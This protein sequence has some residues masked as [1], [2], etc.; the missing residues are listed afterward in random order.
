MVEGRLSTMYASK[1]VLAA[2]SDCPWVVLL[3]GLGGNANTWYK[4]QSVY[5]TQFNL[6]FI[7]LHSVKSSINKDEP[8]TIEAVCK[9]ISDTMDHQGVK[10]AHFVCLSIGT[11]IALAFAATY[12]ERVKSMVLVGGIIKFNIRTRFL[13]FM[14]RVLKKR[15]GYMHLY[16]FFAW[17]ILPRKNHKESRRLFVKE[18]KKIGFMEFSRWVDFIPALINN[19]QILKQ[20]EQAVEPTPI[21]YVM[22]SEDHMFLSQTRKYASLMRQTKVEIIPNCGHV[23]TIEKHQEFS[24]ISMAFMLDFQE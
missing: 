11:M 15:V 23:C 22:G 12:K 20:L 5:A 18:A 1:V 10:T 8:L 3:H 24:E 9:N 6:L 19:G 4:Q 16:R 14:A 7:E 21:L 13:L 17:T 2:S